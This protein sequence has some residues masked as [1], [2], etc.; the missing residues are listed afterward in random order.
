MNYQLT[1]HPD[2]TVLNDPS[3][4]R[5]TWTVPALFIAVGS[6]DLEGVGTYSFTVM[7]GNL[8]SGEVLRL[9]GAQFLALPG[10]FSLI[11]TR[12]GPITGP[13]GFDAVTTS[14]NRVKPTYWY[15]TLTQGATVM[16]SQTILRPP[17]P[18]LL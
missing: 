14:F 1:S 6:T 4:P 13:V 5:L 9:Y 8:L 7:D 11:A 18:P 17:P 10:T 3:Q 16:K 2:P 15:A 12:T